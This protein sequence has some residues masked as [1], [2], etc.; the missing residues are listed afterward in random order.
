MTIFDLFIALG[1]ILCCRRENRFTALIGIAIVQG[2]ILLV[3]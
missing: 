3:R 1:L 2:I